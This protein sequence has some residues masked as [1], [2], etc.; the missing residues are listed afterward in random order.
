MNYKPEPP[1]GGTTNARNCARYEPSIIN[2]CTGFSLIEFL[3]VSAVIG[4]LIII[5]I[6]QFNRMSEGAKLIRANK[7]AIELTTAATQFE[8]DTGRQLQRLDDLVT[9]FNIDNWRGP[10]ADDKDEFTDPWGAPFTIDLSA[11]ET[12][13]T[14]SNIS[15]WVSIDKNGRLQSTQNVD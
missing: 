7:R 10:Y 1:E 12:R 2:R 14:S 8:I 5:G 15:E 4:I 13:V 11:G 9:G 6:W 3:I